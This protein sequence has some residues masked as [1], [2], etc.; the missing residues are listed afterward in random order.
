MSLSASFLP[1]Q[2]TSHVKGV[3][4]CYECEAK[5]APKGFPT[6]TITN[7]PSKVRAGSLP[8]SPILSTLGVRCSLMGIVLASCIHPNSWAVSAS[9]SSRPDL[10]PWRGLSAYDFEGDRAIAQL[11]VECQSTML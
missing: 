3:S 1:L 11:L 9:W 10:L 5:P 7:T 2:V 6:C 8:A 4:Q